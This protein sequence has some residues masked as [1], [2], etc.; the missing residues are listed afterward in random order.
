MCVWYRK[1]AKAYKLDDG[2]KYLLARKG[3]AGN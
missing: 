2:R 3:S 1:E